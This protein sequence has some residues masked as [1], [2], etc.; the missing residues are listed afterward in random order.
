MIHEEVNEGEENESGDGDDEE[1][2]DEINHARLPSAVTRAHSPVKRVH[3]S[4][5][6]T[7]LR[8]IRSHDVSGHVM[9][10]DC[11]NVC[12][13]PLSDDEDGV[14]GSWRCRDS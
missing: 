14:K 3:K 5:V 1:E 2:V 7:H 13:Y 11:T 4:L 8:R 10:S 12:V 6:W 9:K